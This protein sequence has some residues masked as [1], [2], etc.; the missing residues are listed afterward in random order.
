MTH[1]TS[2][3]TNL[4]GTFSLAVADR[5]RGAGVAD[6]GGGEAPA[7]LVALSEFLGGASIRELS[8]VL[9]ITH[10]ATVRLVDGLEAKRLVRRQPGEDGRAVALHPTAA[11]TAKA[12]AILAARAAAL[13]GLLAPLSRDERRQLARLHRR[14]LA[15][16]VESGGDPRHICRQCDTGGCGHESGRCPVTTAARAAA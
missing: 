5:I 11:G 10:S 2:Q 13:D 15:G 1:I 16:L 9:G 6:A 14:L 12:E 4:A 3:A 7:A 8:L